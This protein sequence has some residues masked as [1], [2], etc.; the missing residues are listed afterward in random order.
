MDLMTADGHQVKPQFL[1]MDYIFSICLA[2]KRSGMH[3]ITTKIEHP[4]VSAPMRFL[5]E[6]GFS[7]TWLDVDQ[8][9]ILSLD[10]LREAVTPE[11]ILV[12]VM[13]VNNSGTS[14]PASSQ[15]P[16]RPPMPPVQVQQFQA[17]Q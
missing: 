14:A 12:S 15:N 6:Q 5:E 11:T 1:G 7:V 3:L 10:Q 17:H 16:H 2:N 8:N 13:F 4:A 9:G